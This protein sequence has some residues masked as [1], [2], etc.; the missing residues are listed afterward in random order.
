MSRPGGDPTKIATLSPDGRRQATLTIQGTLT[1]L[2]STY[3]CS[4]QGNKQ[5]AQADQV[6]ANGVALINQ[7]GINLP[8]TTRGNL[9]IGTVLTII[10]NTATTPIVGRFGNL[11][12][13]TIIGLAGG[14]FQAN[15]E[16]GDG[17][18]LTLTV[19]P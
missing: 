19:V 14:N 4:F 10:N 2:S 1:F 11:A 18:D 13:G 6:V 17:N 16:G 12:D 9:R 8:G 5:R 7:P 3:T 15:Y